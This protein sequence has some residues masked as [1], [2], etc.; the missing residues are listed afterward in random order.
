MATLLRLPEVA[1]IPWRK[2]KTLGCGERSR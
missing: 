1:T 2:A